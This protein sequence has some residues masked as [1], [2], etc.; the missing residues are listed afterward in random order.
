MDQNSYRYDYDVKFSLFGIADGHCVNLLNYQ[1]L[2]SFEISAFLQDFDCMESVE[3][4][5]QVTDVIR[6][7]YSLPILCFLQ[8][9]TQNR[10]E[11]PDERNAANVSVLCLGDLG[12]LSNPSLEKSISCLRSYA[13]TLDQTFVSGELRVRDTPLTHFLSPFLGGNSHVSVLMEILTNSSFQAVSD[14]FSLVDSLRKV[15][16]RVEQ[17]FENVL[18]EEVDNLWDQNEKLEEE[19]SQMN[20]RLKSLN[21]SLSRLLNDQ[22]TI[23][24]ERNLLSLGN[25]TQRYFLDYNI[26]RMEL[27]KLS[28]KEQIRSLQIDMGICYSILD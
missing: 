6:K 4:L 25:E 20:L 18:V 26:S 1:K 10:S 27:E 8:I 16:N 17:V 7:G 3:H 2:D 28:V 5:N 22:E 12:S 24:S 19:K 9:R 13:L 21:A 23:K 11:S 14:S 15:K